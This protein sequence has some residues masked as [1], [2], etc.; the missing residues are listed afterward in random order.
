MKQFLSGWQRMQP[1]RVPDKFKR[2]LELQRLEDLFVRQQA[3]IIF[4]PL[5]WGL[6]SI[7]IQVVSPSPEKA[8]WCL[9][10][11]V[12]L[13]LTSWIR[14]RIGLHF[15][16][17]G[18]HDLAARER[19]ILLSV[20]LSALTW[21]GLFSLAV[22]PTPLN[23]HYSLLVTAS[24]GLCAGAATLLNIHK[25]TIEVY[26]LSLLTLPSL[27]VLSGHSQ[28]HPGIAVLFIFFGFSMRGITMY[29]RGEYE[30]TVVANLIL[31]QQTE[32]LTEV[33]LSDALTGVRNRRYF[34]Q[35]FQQEIQRAARLSHPLTLL[36][37]DIDHFKQ[38]N[39]EHGH[40]VGDACLCHVATTI[41]GCLNR[42]G[43]F[44]A[45]YGGEEFAVILAGSGTQEGKR[46][47]EAIRSAVN[48]APFFWRGTRL[49][50]TVSI[51]G[52]SLEEPHPGVKAD[53]FFQATDAALFRAKESGRNLVCWIDCP[54][55]VGEKT[56]DIHFALLPRGRSL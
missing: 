14:H 52:M 4:Y 56:E 26:L 15:M 17:L 35:I 42:A 47:A 9:F 46:V 32:L 45:R 3:G 6:V 51:G 50:V 23:E 53:R 10:I 27:A 28:E 30:K 43:D 38:V 55:H 7:G 2:P 19:C 54:A 1:V 31:K 40:A 16:A 33:S 8:R 20:S 34:D 37:V 21:S 41:E 25:R 11:E 5:I 22:L 18:P 48:Q 49:R 24:L 29:A 36:L 44:V 13:L 39:D 12:V